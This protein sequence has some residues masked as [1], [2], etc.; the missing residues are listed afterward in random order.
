MTERINILRQFLKD[1][2]NDVFSMYA[3]AL[4]YV[5]AVEL[6]KALALMT[7]LLENHPDYLPAYYQLGKLLEQVNNKE[8]ALVTYQ[9]GILL[10]KEK[11]NLHTA[12]ELRGAIDLLEEDDE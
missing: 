1:D 10:A 9:K 5:K 12:S 7:S 4:E 8:E 2:P 3:L 6:K 11:G